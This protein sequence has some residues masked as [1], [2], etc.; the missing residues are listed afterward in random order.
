ML[1]RTWDGT[2]RVICE[3][4]LAGNEDG[5]RRPRK[6]G[7]RPAEVEGN[8]RREVGG[9][10]RDVRGRRRKVGGWRRGV[11]KWRS[12]NLAKGGRRCSTRR[13]AARLVRCVAEGGTRREV[14]GWRRGAGIWRREAGDV[15]QGAP[16]RALC[17]VWRREVGIW[18]QESGGR[19]CESGG[20]TWESR[21]VM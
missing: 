14:G 9:R 7:S 5:S 15:A 19:K 10:R 8:W 20:W 12:R 18:N 6:G 3:E 17:D 11:G 2:Q 21:G 13:A 1:K 4:S 16:Q